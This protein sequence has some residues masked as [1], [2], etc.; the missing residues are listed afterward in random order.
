MRVLLL[1]LLPFYSYA[2]NWDTIKEAYNFNFGGTVGLE[3]LMQPESE[4]I[5]QQVQGFVSN[6]NNRK[7]FKTNEGQNFLKQHMKYVNFFRAKKTLEECE[8][9]KDSNRNL[10]QSIL[11]GILSEDFNSSACKL[12]YIQTIDAT[13]ELFQIANKLQDSQIKDSL[14]DNL[15]INS[16]LNTV[17]ADLT[18]QYKYQPD[19]LNETRPNYSTL[20]ENY[21]E[22][23]KCNFEQKKQIQNTL[24]SFIAKIK[25]KEKKH[26]PEQVHKEINGN[27]DK[28]NSSLAEIEIKRTKGAL[29]DHIDNG[30]HFFVPWMIDTAN[31]DLEDTK[32]QEQFNNYV[33]KFY[34]ANNSEHGILFNTETIREEMGPFRTNND[35]EYIDED[36]KG[37]STTYQFEPHQNVSLSDVEESITDV[38]KAINDHIKNLKEIEEYTSSTRSKLSKDITGQN[39]RQRAQRSRL[40]QAYRKKREEN[41]LFLLK[42]SPRAVSQLLVNSPEYASEICKLL[43]KLDKEDEDSNLDTALMVGGAVLGVAGL[44]TGGVTW[45]FAGGLST[46]AVATLGTTSSALLISSMATGLSGAGI[47]YYQASKVRNDAQAVEAAL[48]SQNGFAESNEFIRD[49]YLD[50]KDSL[51]DLAYEGVFALTGAGA[52]NALN[53]I[54]NSGAIFVS[55]GIQKVAPKLDQNTIR[56]VEGIYRSIGKNKNLKEITK[57]TIQKLGNKGQEKFDEFIILLSQLEDKTRASFLTALSKLPANS[58]RFKDLI[59]KS[60]CSKTR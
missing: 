28:L 60:L 14:Q 16:M 22:K 23:L 3:K 9:N 35:D 46:A 48:I 53:K 56:A 38:D 31:P 44:F 5:I 50:Y 18:H 51:Y 2:T 55:N 58:D 29:A 8:N 40:R 15:L 13:S 1:L 47:G 32:T 34:E 54:K 43:I 39:N 25:S 6:P 11:T 52:L 45:L 21:C 7:I 33:S 4:K 17:E 49:A 26:T 24:P 19:F 57:N 12:E 59:N 20:A 37:W 10:S 30:V 42:T 36:V 41:L 27:I